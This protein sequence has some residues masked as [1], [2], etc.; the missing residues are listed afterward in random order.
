[1][2]ALFYRAFLFFQKENVESLFLFKNPLASLINFNTLKSLVG[3]QYAE[4]IPVN[5]KQLILT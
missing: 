4:I 5:L 3:V 2:D 1:M